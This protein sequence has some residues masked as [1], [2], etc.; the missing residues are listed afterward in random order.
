MSQVD[1]MAASESE[2]KSSSEGQDLEIVLSQWRRERPEIDPSSIAVC[3]AIWQCGERLR[4]GVLSN[5]SQSD[6]DFSGFDVIMTLRRQGR[7]QALSP[8]ALAKEM[9]LSTSAMTNR[10]DRLERRGL[11]ARRRDPNDRRG[12]KI[13]L[14]DAGFALVDGIFASHVVTI[15]NM[16]AHLKTNERD[17]LRDL[18]SKIAM[19]RETD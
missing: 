3:G 4:R 17:Q 15:E 10:L 6:L 16:L 2:S 19:P 12:L 8:S 13:V 5:L 1:T 7:G 18:L 14:S 9:M 11:I